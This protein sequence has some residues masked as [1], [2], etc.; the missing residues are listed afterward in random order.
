M[1]DQDSPVRQQSKVSS[2]DPDFSVRLATVQDLRRITGEAKD[3]T[4]SARWSSDNALLSHIDADS[5]VVLCPLFRNGGP[6]DEPESYRCHVWFVEAAAPQPKVSLVD[7]SRRS[8]DGLPEASTVT[9][10]KKVIR[11]LLDGYPLEALP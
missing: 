8:L 3:H 11:S 10:L 7:V 2:G 6:V 1:T 5:M 4:W 9:Q